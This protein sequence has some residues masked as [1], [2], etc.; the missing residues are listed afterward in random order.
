MIMATENSEQSRR[1]RSDSDE[2]ITKRC[3]VNDEKS[4]VLISTVP[5]AKGS[6]LTCLV[7]WVGWHEN[8][9]KNDPRGYL[10][11]VAGTRLTFNRDPLMLGGDK[12]GVNI[13]A[14]SGICSGDHLGHIATKWTT[15]RSDLKWGHYI[16]ALMDGDKNRLPDTLVDLELEQHL[17]FA[18]VTDE[19]STHRP[20]GSMIKVIITSTYLDKQNMTMVVVE[21]T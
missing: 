1:D 13:V 16:S 8:N 2:Q 4:D 17:T 9:R 5:T 15:P 20:T 7:N 12:L 10:D 18:G 11:I 3:R 14:A 21:R 19:K 6:T